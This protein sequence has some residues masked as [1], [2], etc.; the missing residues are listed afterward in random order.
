MQ[1]QQGVAYCKKQVNR[2]AGKFSVITNGFDEDDF[3]IPV[4]SPSRKDFIITY[5]GTMS[6]HGTSP[7][8]SSKLC[9]AY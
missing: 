5:S 3:K 2:D 7:E 6:E 8:Y 4:S 9:K 1:F